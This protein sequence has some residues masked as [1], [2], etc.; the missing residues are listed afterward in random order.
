[1]I[2]KL[3]FSCSVCLILCNEL[4]DLWILIKKNYAYSWMSDLYYVLNKSV[5]CCLL[6]CFVDY[7]SDF[8]TKQKWPEVQG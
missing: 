5:I 3:S 2:S 1:M 8:D 7:D 6:Y 4:N